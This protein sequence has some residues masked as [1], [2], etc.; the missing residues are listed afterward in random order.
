MKSYKHPYVHCN[1]IYNTQDTEPIEVF[2]DRW[3]DEKEV[4]HTYR[5]LLSNKKEWKLAICNNM[6]GPNEINQT[7]KNKYCMISLTWGN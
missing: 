5:I 1:I 4:T 7:E 3:M 2:T 6:D